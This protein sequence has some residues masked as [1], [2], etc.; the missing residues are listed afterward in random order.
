MPMTAHHLIKK[1]GNIYL[2]NS[3]S[4]NLHKSCNTWPKKTNVYSVFK[5]LYIY[6]TI[7]T[8][9]Q[10]ILKMWN[11]S[12]MSLGFVVLCCWMSLNVCSFQCEHPPC[13]SL[14]PPHTHLPS[15]PLLLI[16]SCPLWPCD[17]SPTPDGPSY[18]PPLLPIMPS[19][20]RVRHT[21]LFV[22]PLPFY[23]MSL[24]LVSL[25]IQWR[26]LAA[27]IGLVGGFWKT[28]TTKKTTQRYHA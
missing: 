5:G 1:I 2:W 6:L 15:F 26:G 13:S 8:W 9:I 19:L 16:C 18:L 17:S 21:F 23:F 10:W 3:A 20:R 28:A 7:N 27:K 25:H 4:S 12:S 22:P 14:L 11:I 24:S